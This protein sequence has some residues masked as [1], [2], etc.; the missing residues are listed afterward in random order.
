MKTPVAAVE[1]ALEEALV[2]EVA[3]DAFKFLA[4]QGALLGAGAQEGLD[5]MAARQEFVDEIG[6]DKPACAGDEDV[7]D[8]LPLS[9]NMNLRQQYRT[10][11]F[12]QKPC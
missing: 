12:F 10:D 11:R 2:G 8:V 6:T 5:A 3:G 1:F 4:E 9:G 7:Q